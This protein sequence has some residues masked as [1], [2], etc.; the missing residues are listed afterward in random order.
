MRNALALAGALAAVAALWGCDKPSSPAAPPAAEPKAAQ[1]TA[2]PPAP[3]VAAPLS[4]N[5]PKRPGMPGFTLDYI[6]EAVDPL[7]RQPAVVK[8]SGPLRVGGFGFDPVSKAPGRGIDLVIDDTVY[9][10]TYGSS[11]PDVARYTKVPAL[12]GT[13]FLTTLPAG[14]VQP[15]P[16]QIIVRIV[17]SDGAAFYESPAILFDTQ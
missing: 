16:H 13:G 2:A 12:S 10:T 1:P 14:A 17:S 15:G 3:G 11:R 9:A 6:N 8:G 4:V 5:L 7:N